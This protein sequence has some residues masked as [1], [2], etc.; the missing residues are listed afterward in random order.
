MKFV[1]I[2]LIVAVAITNAQRYKP[3]CGVVDWS[4]VPNN[5]FY[6]QK[7]PDLEALVLRLLSHPVSVWVKDTRF[8]FPR[9]PSVFIK[10]EKLFSPKTQAEL[11]M[12]SWIENKDKYI[13]H[14]LFVHQ[15]KYEAPLLHD[16]HVDWLKVNELTSYI[17]NFF[18][19]KEIIAEYVE[20]KTKCAYEKK[21]K[22]II[23]YVYRHDFDSHQDYRL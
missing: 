17:E 20:N 21:R 18:A 16:D 8:S 1:L 7:Q 3:H 9:L 5:T 10:D 2:F 11:L 23:P 22:F 4:R 12:Q 13:M 14:V 19:V 6:L 15:T